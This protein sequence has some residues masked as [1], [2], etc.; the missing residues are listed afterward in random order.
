[1]KGVADQNCNIKGQKNCN[2][3]GVALIGKKL[4]YKRSGRIK[5]CNNMKEVAEQKV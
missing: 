2:M 5:S 1:V 3:D 4:Y